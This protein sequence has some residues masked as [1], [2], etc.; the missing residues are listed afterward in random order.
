LQ[1]LQPGKEKST[2][3]IP[4]QIKCA[5]SITSIT[6]NDND[7]ANANDKNTENR[8]IVLVVLLM[9]GSVGWLEFNGTFS[10][11]RLQ[12]AL[13]K[14]ETRMKPL[15]LTMMMVVVLRAVSNNNIIHMVPRVLS[16]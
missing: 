12:R 10:T 9:V 7:S 4:K 14:L 11:K 13:Q 6:D 16:Q 8:K 3:H 1:T 2:C 5:A 15:L